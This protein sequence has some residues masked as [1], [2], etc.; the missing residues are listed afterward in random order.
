MDIFDDPDRILSG[1]D[2]GF[3]LCP[4]TGKVLAPKG[5]RN[6]YTIKKSN[7]KES[8]TVLVVFTASGHI[9]PPLV[10]F[11]YVRPPK[12]V[13]ESL[14][15]S[16]V[17]GKSESGWMKGDIFYEYI[18]NDFNNWL[19]EN[20]I[21]K[22]IIVFI[23]GHRSHMTLSLR[24]FCEKNEII[25]YALPQNT[26]HMLQP[27]DVSVFRP[28][29]QGWKNTVRNWQ[30]KPENINSSVTKINFSSRKLYQLLI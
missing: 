25:L 28:S 26:T 29:K 4:K 22:P 3:S 16:W 2:S 23:D 9:C 14:P 24:K 19:T 11:P 15:E 6:L 20:S 13:I 17:L 7:D 10:V 21:K 18:A 27:A 12:A 5:W 8:I 1:D 30:S